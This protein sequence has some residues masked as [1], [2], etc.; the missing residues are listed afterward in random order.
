MSKTTDCKQIIIGMEPYDSL[1][2]T[3]RVPM[4]SSSYYMLEEG[5]FDSPKVILI[6]DWVPLLERNGVEESFV[7]PLD[8][9]TYKE[10]ESITTE[11]YF[12]YVRLGTSNF[13]QRNKKIGFSVIHP[14]TLQHVRDSQAK[15]VIVF[16][17][18]GN[19]GMPQF[20]DSFTILQDWCTEY[21]IPENNVYF[22]TGNMKAQQLFGHLVKYNIVCIH[23]WDCLND[24]NKFNIIP[25][26]PVDENSLYVNLNRSRYKHRLLMLIN[27]LKEGLL[28]RGLNSFNYEDVDFTA[29]VGEYIAQDQTL[30]FYGQ[31]L[32]EIGSNV[33]DFP[34]T[35]HYMNYTVNT[36]FYKKTFVSIVPESHC[37][38][39]TI[40]FS[41]KTWKPMYTGHPFLLLGSPGQLNYLKTQGFQTFD[42][43]FDESYDDYDNLY[44][45]IKIITN[46]LKKYSTYTIDQLIALRKEMEPVIQHNYYHLQQLYNKKYIFDDVTHPNGRKP[47]LDKLLQ[48]LTDWK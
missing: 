26:E 45:R 25:Y 3:N 27:L 33:L 21:N 38:S 1:I 6:N 14:K 42:K 12:Y 40:H 32:I 2:K 35:N 39:E 48:I 5:Q 28:H 7:K 20:P 47:H 10:I 43:W 41:E 16:T 8:F 46:N 44:D 4:S 22:F 17:D 37:E 13:F 29:Y 9:V 11:K 15:I 23:N 19:Q 34:Y 18:E 24:P 36:D 30:Q 31:K